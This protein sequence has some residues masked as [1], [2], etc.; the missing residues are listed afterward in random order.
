MSDGEEAGVHHQE[1]AGEAGPGHGGPTYRDQ[2]QNSFIFLVSCT[3]YSL[4]RIRIRLL[5][6]DR[7]TDTIF[8]PTPIRQK[9]FSSG[10]IRMR[11]TACEKRKHGKNYRRCGGL[12]VRVVSVAAS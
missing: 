3:F 5:N 4:A 11:N 1:Q 7:H 10:P 9:K 12:V 2:G 6:S 8:T